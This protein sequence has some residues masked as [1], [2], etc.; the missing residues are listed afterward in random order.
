MEEE[1]ETGAT[2]VEEAAAE[3]TA[4]EE[5]AVEEA[6]AEEEPVDTGL[7]SVEEGVEGAAVTMAGLWGM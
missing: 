2:A 1:T 7:T 4:A 6:A 5:A 3:E